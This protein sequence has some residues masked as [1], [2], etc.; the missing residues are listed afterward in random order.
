MTSEGGGAVAFPLVTLAPKFAPVTARDFSL[1]VQAKGMTWALFEI[2][3]MGVQIEKRAV[4]FG[5][6][7]SVPGFIFGSLLVDLFF[8]GLQ[9]KML[10]VSTWSSFAVALYLLDA[11]KIGEPFM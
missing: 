9:Q 8:K 1:I 11:E 3:F 5:M 4:V 7:G 6:M 2:V 10:Y